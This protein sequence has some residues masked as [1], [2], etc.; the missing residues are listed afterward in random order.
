M[1]KVLKSLSNILT[2]FVLNIL[3]QQKM[4]WL[5]LEN[6]NFL[7]NIYQYFPIF[8]EKYTKIKDF[9]FQIQLELIMI[10]Q[11]NQLQNKLLR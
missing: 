7:L 5:H 6:F 1:N 3:I 8:N 9:K 4:Q 11:S 2:P 10:V